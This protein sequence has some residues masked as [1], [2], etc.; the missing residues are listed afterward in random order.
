MVLGKNNTFMNMVKLSCLLK[1][2]VKLYNRL[3]ESCVWNRER[4]KGRADEERGI[5]VITEKE[6]SGI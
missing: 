2:S 4:E 1:S 3:P 6:E 5:E